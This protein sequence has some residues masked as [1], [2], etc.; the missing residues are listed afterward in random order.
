MLHLHTL[1]STVAHGVQVFVHRLF[2]VVKNHR[3]LRGTTLTM[4]GPNI[5]FPAVF[6]CLLVPFRSFGLIFK[7][8]F[9]LFYLTIGSYLAC[10]YRVMEHEGS[11]ESPEET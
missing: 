1:N 2:H 10:L 7:M 4:S 9:L 5:F 3:G 6:F 11:S 8:D